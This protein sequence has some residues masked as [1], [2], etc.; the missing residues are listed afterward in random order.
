MRSVAFLVAGCDALVLA[1]ALGCG[2]S[3]GGVSDASIDASADCSPQPFTPPAFVPPRA[4]RSACTDTQIQTFI[5]DCFVFTDMANSPAA[6]DAFEG[7][8][9]N[10]PCILCM[11]TDLTDPAYG[12]IIRFPDSTDTANIGGCIALLDQDAGPGSCA[13]AVQA[14]DVCK[15]GSC[16]AANCPSG[17]TTSG[18]QL[19]DQCQSQALATI[20]APYAAAAQCDEAVQYMP[21]LFADFQAYALG[22]G[23]IFCEAA[24]DGGAGGQPDGGQPDAQAP[25]L[26]SGPDATGSFDGGTPVEAASD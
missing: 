24:A 3:E 1:A 2:G 11:Q 21:C 16:A 18:L 13:A 7:D 4:P 17:S 6:C 20:C 22:L 23:R 5:S 9:A 19:F 10:S 26:D 8:P 25:Q 15:H 12:P 14:R